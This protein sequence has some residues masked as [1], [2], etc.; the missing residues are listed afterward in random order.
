[1]RLQ[2]SSTRMERRRVTLGVSAIALAALAPAPA[3]DIVTQTPI[4]HVI[5][6]IGENRSFDNIFAA[7]RAVHGQSVGNLLSKGI[8]TA[9]GLP[10]PNAA[11]ATQYIVNTPLPSNYFMGSGF[12]KTAYAPYLPTPELGG[13]PNRQISPADL[14]AD[15][16]GVQPPFNSQFTS[17]QL[18]VLEP[19]FENRDL[20][21]LRTG[22]TGAA[23][24]TGPDVRVA[25]YAKLPNT[26]FALTG[27]SLAYDSYTGDMVHRLFHM[28]QQSDCNLQNATPANPSG[29]LNDLYPF[30]GVARGDDSGANSMGFYNVQRGDA[31][32]LKKLADEYALS[33]NFHQSIMGGT[34]ANHIALGTGDAIFWTT[35]NGMLQ[36]PAGAVANPDP[37]SPTSDKYKNDKQWA[38]C[39][40]STQ[41][42]IA[43]IVNYLSSL[44]YHPDRNCEPGHF[45]LI[46]N[47]SPGFL[48]N[49]EID[50]ASI[51]AGTK[52][53]P[54]ALRTIGDAL[55][56]KSIS[57]AY[58][59]G[60]Y[61]AAVRVANGSKDP[62]DQFLA[63]NYCD[64]CNFESYA[65]SIMSNPAQRA[66]HIKDVTDFFDDLEDN[67]LPAVS[68]VKPDSM[69]DGHPASSKL[70]LF[71]A[72]LENIVD[73]LTSHPALFK[74][75]ALFVAFDEAGG[76]W[77]SGY[78]Q[79][80]DFFGDG[81]RIPFIAVSP[82]SRGGKVV[83]AYYDHVSVLKFI[84]RNWALPPLT[85]RSRDNLPNPTATASNPYVPTNAPAI[86]DLFDMFDFSRGRY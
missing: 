1:M 31:P 73:K 68:F 70:D 13:A 36:P 12:T 58:Y 63:N 26:V 14:A 49:G 15:P 35:F 85:G 65:S 23:G 74:D 66:A 41:P 18:A 81:P 37:Q 9:D 57:W 59:G 82:F 43:P 24:S 55:N 21:L 44:P 10:G 64:I 11:A 20:F 42:G 84:E 47:L 79:P 53:P 17:S 3:H 77:D 80:L 6:L 78:F 76:Y 28:W 67:H 38:N 61:N 30:V 56:E 22:A 8:I 33:D 46:N 51:M 69:V 50:T 34:A 52:V 2:K 39:S 62:V 32:V 72:M 19:S 71:E 60:G 5:V 29:C 48:P 54:S 75:A 86:G 4:K 25:N 83:H 16:T 40:D 45:Y 7:Y 27:P